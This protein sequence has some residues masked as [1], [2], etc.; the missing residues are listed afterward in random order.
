VAILR[1]LEKA[2]VT[3][4][5]RC[6]VE[7]TARDRSETALRLLGQLLDR[8]RDARLWPHVDVAVAV[9]PG[10][11]FEICPAVP[12]DLCIFGHSLCEQFQ[13]QT[14]AHL[15]RLPPSLVAVLDRALAPAGVAVVIEPILRTNPG[16]IIE[17]RNALA[18]AQELSIL[19]PCPTSQ[20]ACPEIGRGRLCGAT[21]KPLRFLLDSPAANDLLLC[22]EL[23]G[24]AVREARWAVIR[25]YTQLRFGALVLARRSAAV[26]PAETG[27]WVMREKRG[28]DCGYMC[29]DGQNRG[30]I[31]LHIAEPGRTPTQT[32][33]EVMQFV[34]DPL[35]AADGQVRKVSAL[36][37]DGWI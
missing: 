24:L 31:V 12:F 32:H 30:P 25:G 18:S 7:L 33:F 2:C 10:D 8:C 34:S 5:R 13:G 1:A 22:A 28:V 17:L 16:T 29:V 6:Q 35:N 23:S 15:Q 37:Q 3:V 27:T 4:G 26:R 14:A 19:G 21:A 11:M 9:E 20:G 36:Y